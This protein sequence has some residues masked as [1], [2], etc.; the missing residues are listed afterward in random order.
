MA[1]AKKTLHLAT[2]GELERA[3]RQRRRNSGNETAECCH[4]QR[5]DF[6]L[7]GAAVARRRRRGGPG[8]RGSPLGKT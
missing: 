6:G 7:D 4:R 1:S 5:P 3:N 8:R 2:V